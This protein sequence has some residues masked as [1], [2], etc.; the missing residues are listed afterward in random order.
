MKRSEIAHLLPGI[1]QRTL[2]PENPLD[3]MLGAMES[4]HA[5][6]EAILDQI[7]SMC[8]PHRAS[9]AFVPF[10]AHWVDLERIFAPREEGDNLVSTGLGRL[11]ELIRIAPYLSK[12]RGTKQGLQR[13]LETAT[14]V[15]GFAIEEPEAQPFHIR[16][17]AP[18][19]VEPHRALIERIVDVERPVYATWEVQFSNEPPK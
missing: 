12:W 10:L 15:T 11:R 5:P 17:I 16:I 2:A 13:F 4:L 14:G 8:N 19:E 7:D 1:F 9:D 3:A 6:A 18:R